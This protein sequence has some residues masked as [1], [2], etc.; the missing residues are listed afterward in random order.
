MTIC[1]LSNYGFL[2]YT[3]QSNIS[4]FYLRSSSP[5]FKAINMAE[6]RQRHASKEISSTAPSTEET[7]EHLRGILLQAKEKIGHNVSDSDRESTLTDYGYPSGQ[8]SPIAS[9]STALLEVEVVKGSQVERTLACDSKAVED[10]VKGKLKILNS[11]IIKQ[12]ALEHKAEML[13]LCIAGKRDIPLEWR[14]NRT[15][16]VLPAGLTFGFQTLKEIR[17]LQLLNEK[18]W[19]QLI[20]RDITRTQLPLV[21][22]QIESTVAENKQEIT[23]DIG[24]SHRTSALQL[25]TSGLEAKLKDRHKQFSQHQQSTKHPAPKPSTSRYRPNQ[26][27]RKPSRRFDPVERHHRDSSRRDD[28]VERQRRDDRE[29][30]DNTRGRKRYES[31]GWTKSNHR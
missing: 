1:F 29:E 12:A 8:R 25:F 22:G 31:A 5:V 28:R 19:L 30:R 17:Q 24:E 6:Q 7:A 4:S 14:D 13:A 10:H 11:L 15:L 16:P 9:K 20:H 18:A 26:R 2:V 21:K 23:R 27:S 3:R